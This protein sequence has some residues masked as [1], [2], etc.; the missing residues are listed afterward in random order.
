VSGQLYTGTTNISGGTL[1]LSTNG[2]TQT[3]L[4]GT[5]AVNL[6]NGGRLRLNSTSSTTF[7]Q[8]LDVGT[9]GGTISYRGNGSFNPTA[10]TV[11]ARW[12]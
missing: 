7:N 1:Q 11:P 3:N 9:G 10:I 2:N 4:L 6:S 8:A 5:G 12:P